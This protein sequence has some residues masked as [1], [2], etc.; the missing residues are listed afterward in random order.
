V[1]CPAC[2]HDTREGARFCDVC[3]IALSSSSFQHLLTAADGAVTM[4]A[5]QEAID[6][7]QAALDLA[8]VHP[9]KRTDG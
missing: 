2:G 8:T 9:Q 7:L 4:G 1:S 3:G 6:H 5:N